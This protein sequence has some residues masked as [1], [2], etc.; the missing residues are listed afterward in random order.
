[1]YDPPQRIEAQVFARLPDSFRAPDR[2]SAWV[3]ARQHKQVHSFLEGPAFDRNGMLY[4]TDIPFGRIFAI[5]PVPGSSGVGNAGMVHA[6]EIPWHG[7]PYS[8]LVRVPP[9][10]ALWL[11]PG[12]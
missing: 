11:T 1:M 4:C 2:R 12:S 5:D 9:L 6:D 3:D 8:A 7:L 10:G